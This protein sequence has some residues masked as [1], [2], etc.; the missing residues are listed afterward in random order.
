MSS[1][2]EEIVIKGYFLAQRQYSLDRLGACVA[3]NTCTSAD[4]PAAVR[5]VFRVLLWNI[6]AGLISWSK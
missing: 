1:E 3:L 5:A 6:T 2:L 4:V